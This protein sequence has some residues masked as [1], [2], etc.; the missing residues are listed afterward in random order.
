MLEHMPEEVD[1]F[2]PTYMDIAGRRH[3]E[4]YR[5]MFDHGLK[6]LLSPIIG[7]DILGRDEQYIYEMLLPGL[8]HLVT[9]PY[10]LDF[11]ESHKVG[12]RF[13]G[14]YRKYLKPDLADLLDSITERTQQHTQR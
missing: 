8:A 14:D 7:P 11:Y 10:F 12:V 5:M 13:Y 4:L 1:D 6:Y 2:W 3:V 9:Q